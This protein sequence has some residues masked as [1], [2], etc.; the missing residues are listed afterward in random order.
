MMARDRII[1]ELRAAFEHEP[2][3]N[4]HAHPVRIDFDGEAL[5]LEGDVE[6][7]VAKKLS[8]EL[9]G[10]MPGVHGVVDRLR[11]IPAEPREDGA[12]RDG[13][14]RALLDEQAMTNCTLRAWIK[15]QVE[16]LRE[17]LAADSCGNIEVSVENGVVTLDGEVISLSHKRLAGVLAWWTPGIRDVINGLEVSPPEQDTDDEVTDALRIVLEKDPLV[18]E[19]EQ[20][21]VRTH[22][23]EVT[24]E[25]LVTG[26]SER[27]MAELDAWYLFGVDKVINNIEVSR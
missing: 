8:L 27:H 1:K 4:L 3:I 14:C 2:C 23:Y 24:L 11:V 6:D 12:I 20:I 9:A 21:S 26:E 13:V 25:G 10:A 16:T 19:P 18:K 5:V 15:G 17:I 7:I 22:N